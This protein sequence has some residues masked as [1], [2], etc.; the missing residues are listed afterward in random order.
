MNP[1]MQLHLDFSHCDPIN[2][3][4]LLDLPGNDSRRK[5]SAASKSPQKWRFQVVFNAKNVAGEA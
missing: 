5:L 2:S 1:A 3:L 4:C